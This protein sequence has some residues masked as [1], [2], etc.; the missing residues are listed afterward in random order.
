MLTLAMPATVTDLAETFAAGGSVDRF[1]WAMARQQIADGVSFALRL[2]N[3]EAVVTGGFFPA[4]DGAHE[5]WFRPAPVAA[6]HMREV[7][8]AARLTLSL[9][10]ENAIIRTV[11]HTRAGERVAALSGFT[12]IAASGEIGVWQHGRDNRQFVR[13]RGGAKAGKACPPAGGSG[14]PPA[15]GA[16]GVTAG[17]SGSGS[18]QRDTACAAGAAAVD[19]PE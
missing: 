15:T 7:V 14:E 8:K 17:G 3:G 19:L 16:D 13:R 10:P 11:T 9:L 6:R 5:A 1:L 2:A 12:R 18:G 4:D